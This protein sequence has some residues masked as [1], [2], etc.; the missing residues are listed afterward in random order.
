MCAAYL[1]NDVLH[2]QVYVLAAWHEVD[3]EVTGFRVDKGHKI[4]VALA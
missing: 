3:Y 2:P 1:G 4:F